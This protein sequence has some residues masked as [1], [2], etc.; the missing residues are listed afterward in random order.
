M[1]RLAVAWSP[2]RRS[3]RR[4]HRLCLGRRDVPGG[5]GIDEVRS[6]RE[7]PLLGDR[8]LE[9]GPVHGWPDHLGLVRQQRYAG[10]FDPCPVNL[11]IPIHGAVVAGRRFGQF[12]VLHF[13]GLWTGTQLD[14]YSQL[15][16][17]LYREGRLMVTPDLN[18]A[19]HLVWEPWKGIDARVPVYALTFDTQKG[20]GNES[21]TFCQSRQKSE[22]V[23]S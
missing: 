3:Q 21:V 2:L 1:A 23:V 17:G 18:P 12:D 10:S 22:M 14:G 5:V 9:R 11:V 6:S 19:A 7:G 15:L 20:Q 8:A 13:I 4:A 16:I